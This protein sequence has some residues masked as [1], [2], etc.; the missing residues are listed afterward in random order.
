MFHASLAHIFLESGAI[1]ASAYSDQ[2]G[3][4]QKSLPGAVSKIRGLSLSYDFERPDPE[5][6]QVYGKK[7]RTG[8]DVLV[9]CHVVG[10]ITKSMTRC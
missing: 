2:I 1:H 3:A 4:F 7:T 6:L 8:V 5:A 10:D 9:A